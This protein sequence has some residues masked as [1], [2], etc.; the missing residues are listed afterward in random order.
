MANT[1]TG[2]TVVPST[3]TGT[4]NGVTYNNGKPYLVVQGVLLDPNSLTSVIDQDGNNGSND[5]DSALNYIG[6][7]ITSN[8]PI[9]LVEDGLVSGTE[10]AFN[11]DT[12]KDVTIKIYDAFDELVKTI[13]LPSSETAGKENKIEWDGLSDSGSKVSDGLYYYTVKTDSGYAKT[14]VSGEVSGIKY[15]NNSQYLVMKDTGRLVSISTM[16]GVN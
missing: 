9:V 2:Y 10:L 1:G 4:V 15:L 13:T 14:P 6:K 11:L 5:S 7:T 3:V 12:Q 8:S 16:T